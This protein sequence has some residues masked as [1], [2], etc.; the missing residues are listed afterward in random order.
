MVKDILLDVGIGEVRLA[1]LEN[2]ELSEVYVERREGESLVGNVY[3]G[4]VARVLPGMQSAFVD[5]GMTR[6]AFLYV[7]D[8]I[9]VQYDE[10]G[11][12]IFLEDGLPSIREYLTEGQE[13]TVQITKEQTGNKGPRVTTRL[14]VP[15]RFAVLLPNNPIL[16]ISKRIENQDERLRLREIALRHKPD[17]AGLIMRT[18]SE[19]I[20]ENDLACEIK[21]LEDTWRDIT[22]REAKGSVPRCLLR[23]P[24]FVMHAVREYLSADLNRFVVNDRDEYDKIMEMLD[25]TSPGLKM[26]VECFSKSYDLFEYYHVESGIEEALSRKVWMKSGAYLIFDKTEALTVIDVNSGKNVGKANLEETALKI[27]ME[28]AKTVARQIRLRDL[29][30]IIVV[31]FIDMQD[32]EHREKVVATLREAVK[33]D[34]TQTVVVGMTSLGLVEITRKK[35][36]QPLAKGLTVDCRCC[37]GTGWHISPVTIARKHEKRMARHLAD[38]LQG[39]AEFLVHPE[40]CQVLTGSEKENVRKLEELYSCK[41]SIKASHDVDYDEMQIK[42]LNL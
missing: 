5:I 25:A 23:E 41:L 31:D 37:H 10:N 42:I 7:K 29:S 14:T 12:M 35:V 4:R 15:G 2:G 17:H 30:G 1:V 8:V 3:R 38:T 13:V 36:R 39:F 9:P 11:E 33:G 19:N 18:A 28:A 26:K 24:G 20:E 16:G 32:K 6:N 22:K 27:N 40:I 34:R 21:A